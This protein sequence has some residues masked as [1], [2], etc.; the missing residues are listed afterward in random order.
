MEWSPAGTK[1]ALCML[2]DTIKESSKDLLLFINILFCG[3]T[4]YT[5]DV[6]CDKLDEKIIGENVYNFNL[7]NIKGFI[8]HMATSGNLFS[9]FKDAVKNIIKDFGIDPNMDLSSGSILDMGKSLATSKIPF[10]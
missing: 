2:R 6:C 10:R 5:L 8:I 4:G 7:D 3:L 1:S 9:I